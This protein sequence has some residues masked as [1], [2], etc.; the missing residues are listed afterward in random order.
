MR[1]VVKRPDGTEEIVEGTPEEIREYEKLVNGPHKESDKKQPFVIKGNEQPADPS[2]DAQAEFERIIERM[3]EQQ[4]RSREVEPA[5]PWSPWRPAGPIWV[6]PECSI[7]R[8][9]HCRCFHLDPT[10]IYCTLSG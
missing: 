5:L 2:R 1:K 8:S 4:R 10:K 7:C 6:V 9:T 3:R